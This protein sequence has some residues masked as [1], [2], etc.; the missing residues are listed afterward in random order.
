MAE[1]KKDEK[2]LVGAGEEQ[3]RESEGGKQEKAEDINSASSEE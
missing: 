3:K 1:E 2:P